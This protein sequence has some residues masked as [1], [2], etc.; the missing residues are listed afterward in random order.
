MEIPGITTPSFL[1]I[2]ASSKALIGLGGSLATVLEK[3]VEIVPD[4]ACAVWT[5][6]R[7][8]R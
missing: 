5:T 1:P 3:V 8:N 6:E 2:Q 4:T 7:S